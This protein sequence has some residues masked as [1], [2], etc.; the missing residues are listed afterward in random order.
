MAII[1]KL[2][3]VLGLDPR[4]FDKRLKGTEKSLKRTA[5]KLQDIGRGLTVGVTAPILGIGAVAIK[6]F[7]SFDSAMTKSVAIMGDVTDRMEELQEA[8]LDVGRT[9][10]FGAEQAAEAFFFLASAG[11]DVDKSIAALPKVAAFAQAGMFDLATATDL[12]TDAQSALGLSAED[13]EENMENL[14]RVSDVLVKANTIANASVQQFSESLTN[15]AA[16]SAR[17]AKIEI[18]E[19]VSVLAAFA[20]QGIKGAEAGTK[21][22]IVVRD[23]STKAVTNAKAFEK[24]GITVFDVTGDLIPLAQII[25]QLEQ[26]F[27]NVGLE[28]QKAAFQQLGFA[29]R[30]IGALQ[31]LLGLSDQIEKYE[32]QLKSAGGITETVAQNQLK[33]FAAQMKIVRNRIKEVFIA[34]GA[35]LVPIFKD[36]V[37]PILENAIKGFGSIIKTFSELDTGTKKIIVGLIGLAAALGPAALAMAALIKVMIALKIVLLSPA[38]ALITVGGGLI[39]GLTLL[40]QK[41]LITEA[42]AEAFRG[43]M[44]GATDAMKQ[45]AAAGRT[46]AEQLIIIEQSQIQQKIHELNVQLTLMKETIKSGARPDNILTDLRIQAIATEDQVKQLAQRLTELSK[47]KIDPTGGGGPDAGGTEAPDPN[48]LFGPIL[49]GLDELKEKSSA[50]FTG[51]KE[52]G[53]SAFTSI[54]ETIQG[55]IVTADERFAAFMTSISEKQEAFRQQANEA[56]TDYL[57]VSTDVLSNVKLAALDFVQS[58]SAGFGDAI[59]Q[60]IVFQEDF[61]EVMKKFLTNLLAQVVSTITQIVTNWLIGTIAQAVIGTAIHTQRVGQA[62]Q[63]IYLASVSAF[64]AIPIVGPIIA[65]ALAATATTAAASASIAAASAGAAVAGAGSIPL[66]LDTGG[67][68]LGEGIAK[69]H[70]G[71]RVLR[72]DEVKSMPE[73]MNQMMTVI[74]ELDGQVIA[75]KI[76]PRISRELRM[77]GVGK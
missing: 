68:I 65:P 25:R 75:Q 27:G 16:A 64:S 4:E 77:R 21:F 46:L 14:V 29:D 20:D 54:G 70:T 36:E 39:I 48:A 35:E 22:A 30:S 9:T 44:V 42:A 17:N 53:M 66:A 1:Q 67:L 15:Q 18:E 10:T 3:A 41:F 73:S 43:E 52:V 19:V 5:A 7:A 37:L 50:I 49:S 6:S 55:V 47:L 72:A 60:I 40:A 31:S 12:L 34:L 13:A 33:S 24:F 8:A 23:L 74:V 71:E 56:W 38:F 62:L 11:L 51:L 59:A 26:R 76:V 45:A 32:R 63:M 2:I 61:E 69:L 58:F 28:A 57:A